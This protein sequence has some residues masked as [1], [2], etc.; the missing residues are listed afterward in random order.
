MG[1]SLFG[2]LLR[3][4]LALAAGALVGA[5]FVQPRPLEEI[6]DTPLLSDEF[7]DFGPVETCHDENPCM[8]SQ[9][10]SWQACIHEPD[11]ALVPDDG[12]DCTV[13]VCTD[14]VASH[15]PAAAGTPCGLNGA[16]QCDGKG[17]CAGCSGSRRSRSRCR[18]QVTAYSEHRCGRQ[19]RRC[20]SVVRRLRAVRR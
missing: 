3:F 9:C 11:D 19:I 8:R 14:G 1:R 5:C 2:L 20:R 17:T 7:C 16:L 13:D 4:P 12:Q 18:F 10:T 6:F 15:E